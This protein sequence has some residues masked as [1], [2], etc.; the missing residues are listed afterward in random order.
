MAGWP[1]WVRLAF[2]VRR[3]Q[4]MGERRR[5]VRKEHLAEPYPDIVRFRHDSPAATS[6]RQFPE[7]ERLGLP[8]A[9][10]LETASPK[11][12]LVASHLITAGI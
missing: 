12:H 11:T 1:C 8:L 4:P 6:A 5:L 7:Y 3:G 10:P 2:D 9:G